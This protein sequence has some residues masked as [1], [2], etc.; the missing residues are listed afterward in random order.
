VTPSPSQKSVFRLARPSFHFSLLTQFTL[1]GL[2][3]TAG[4]MIILAYVLRER[5]VQ[6][7]LQEVATETGEQVDRI[8]APNLT[9]TDLAGLTAGRYTY[10][11]NLIR[12]EV[13]GQQILQVKIWSRQGVLIYSNERSSVKETYPVS[14][15]LSQAL[16]GETLTDVSSLNQSSTPPGANPTV[17]REFEIYVPLRINSSQVVGAY[18]ITHDAESVQARIDELQRLVYGSIVASFVILYLCLYLLVRHASHELSRSTAENA[19]LFEEEQTRRQELAALYEFSR[20]LSD[21]SDHEYMLDLIARRAVE[22]VRVTFARVALLEGDELVIRAGYPIREFGHGLEVGRHERLADLPYIQ[23]ALRSEPLIVR[24]DSPSLGEHEGEVLFLGV[25][26]ALCVVPL[27]IDDQMLG[28]LLLGE[29]RNPEREPFAAEK[30]RL[31]RGIGDQAAS[32]L[33]RAALYWQTVRDTAELALA[34]DATIEGWSRALDLRDKETEGHTVRVTKMTELLALALGMEPGMLVHIR[35]GALLHD[36]GK[37]A[38]PDSILLKP[39]PLT[40]EERAIMRR[41]PEYAYELLAP[42]AYLGPALEIPYCHHEKWDGTGYPRRL[43]GEAIPLAAR[44]FAVVDVWDALMSG[45]P[46]RIAWPEQQVYE[47]IQSLSGIQFDPHAVRAF[48]DIPERQKTQLRL[49]G[50]SDTSIASPIRL[51]LALKKLVESSSSQRPS[52]T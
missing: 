46:Y 6:N 26:K 3:L 49:E 19:R 51:S 39:G 21:T 22:T 18:E 17:P 44:M 7:A 38:I 4:I 24:Q 31:A 20:T 41:H 37:M 36:I 16:G 23:H 32:A 47:Y 43:A 12:D 29:A 10:L 30:I 5:L 14:S 35:R 50:T 1:L 48:L 11:D 9:T 28:W 15:K 27:R 45:R 2:V 52:L 40:L 34:Y 8:V 25:A 33:H 42:I 13:I